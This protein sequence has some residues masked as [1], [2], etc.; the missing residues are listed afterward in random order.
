[1]AVATKKE[2]GPSA[3]QRKGGSPA[4]KGAS[5]SAAREQAITNEVIARY[6]KTSDPR[7][8]ELMTALIKHLHG[9]ARDVRLTT[10]EWIGACNYLAMAGEF[11]KGGRQEFLGVSA[12][13]G[14]ETLI[15]EMSVPKPKGATLPTVLGPFYVP[16]SPNFPHAG[17][18]SQGAAGEPLFVSGRV[19]DMKGK[20]VANAS[21]EAWHSDGRG[22]YDVQCGDIAKDGMWCRG[23]LKTDSEGRYSFWSVTPVPYP[24]PLDGGMG[25]IFKH[26]SNHEWRPAHLH[27]MVTGKGLAPLVT[28]IFVRGSKYL[29]ED[30]AFGVRDGLVA[31]FKPN[32][33][34]KGPD[35]REVSKPY[36]ALNYDFVMTHA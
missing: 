15:H 20:P 21:V 22:L 25:A 29:E 30:T 7:M 3:A 24:A 5:S 10:D 2:T 31:D 9:F 33:A 35:G 12:L 27:F 34:D 23:Q 16:N 4:R 1:M 19:L 36:R 13:L 6:S 32:N 17:D 14:L 28:E 8:R 11:C 26:T 18:L